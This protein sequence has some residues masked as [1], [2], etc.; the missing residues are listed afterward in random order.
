[1]SSPFNADAITLNNFEGIIKVRK[2]PVVV[3][4]LQL[5]FVEGFQVTTPEGVMTGRC[6]DYLMF[7]VAGEKYPCQKE[8]FASTYDILSPRQEE[9]TKDE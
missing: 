4:A 9:A 5:N 3:H 6:G 7:G 8:I 2:R 1:M